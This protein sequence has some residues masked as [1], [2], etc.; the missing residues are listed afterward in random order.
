MKQRNIWML[1]LIFGALSSFYSCKEVVD[2]VI[3]NEYRFTNQTGGSV[4]FAAFYR[5]N[6]VSAYLPAPAVV[7]QQ[8][9]T[10]CQQ[11][12]MLFGT[13]YDH[14][15]IDDSVVVTSGIIAL[16]DSLV[17]RFGDKRQAVFTLPS[18]TMPCNLLNLNN[19]NSEK[20][21][22]HYTVYSYVLTE[23]D[24]NA[25]LPLNLD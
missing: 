21:K 16:A 18:D 1:P 8:D 13:V 17:I 9:S 19:Y 2:P 7:L 22:E 14:V 25:A 24:V 3:I 4:S 12:D 10:F 15:I 11:L 23:K 20:I 5:N 6:A